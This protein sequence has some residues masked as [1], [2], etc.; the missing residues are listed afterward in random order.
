MRLAR[1]ITII[2]SASDPA[3]QYLLGMSSRAHKIIEE[4]Y[5]LPEEEQAEVLEAI[6]PTSLEDFEPDYRA[7]IERRLRSIEDGTAVLLDHD[8]VMARL[9]AKFPG[10]LSEDDA[11]MRE[12]DTRLE[13]YDRGEAVLHTPDEVVRHIKAKYQRA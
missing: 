1:P 5:A 10:V 8:E 13:R 11:L 6:V 3:L 7:E 2:V 4:F 9:S 12:V